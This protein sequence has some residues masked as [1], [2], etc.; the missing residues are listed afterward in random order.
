M[1]IM[2][3]FDML[4][5]IEDYI[6]EELENDNIT[7]NKADVSYRNLGKLAVA[8]TGF[9]LKQIGRGEV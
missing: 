4:M 3:I 2:E 9:N 1:E 6:Y 8:L 7:Q 5:E